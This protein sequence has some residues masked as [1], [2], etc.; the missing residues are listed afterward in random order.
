MYD[1]LE[2]IN[3]FNTIW[4]DIDL[5]HISNTRTIWIC[6]NTIWDDI[7]LKLSPLHDKDL[8]RFNT[9]WDDIDLKPQIK[10][11]HL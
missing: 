4:D 9:I 3:G 7:D 2:P 6:F 11:L 8:N 5:K 1:T 10:E